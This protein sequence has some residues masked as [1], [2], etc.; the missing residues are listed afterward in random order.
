MKKEEKKII[1]VLEIIKSRRND[2]KE[3]LIQQQRIE[4]E[5]QNKGLSGSAIFFSPEIIMLRNMISY[6]GQ[7]EWEIEE[8][9]K[10]VWCKGKNM[11]KQYK[12]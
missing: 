4:Q 6:L 11:K 2:L 12:K 9:L 1:R 3:Q 10:R 7:M 5:N 8:I